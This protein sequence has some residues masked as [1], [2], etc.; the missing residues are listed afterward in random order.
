MENPDHEKETKE[1][2][3]GN[4][5]INDNSGDR[6]ENES[7]QKID[8]TVDNGSS[9]TDKRN[10]STEDPSTE[11][12]STDTSST[13][14]RTTENRTTINR[15][16]EPRI[17]E[18]LG[19]VIENYHVLSPTEHL[20]MRLEIF[21]TDNDRIR[22]LERMVRKHMTLCNHIRHEAMFSDAV[23]YPVTTAIE[24]NSFHVWLEWHSENQHQKYARIFLRLLYERDYLRDIF[25][26]IMRSDGRGHRTGIVLTDNFHNGLHYL[27]TTFKMEMIL[28]GVPLTAFP[29]FSCC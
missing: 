10:H 9:E 20:L 17:T 19:A 23:P 8:K 15:T 3:I 28:K 2:D 14:Y 16:T 12:R 21:F 26:R 5:G 11:N 7:G 27:A 25:K 18:N 24:R 13:E 4:K 29:D 6:I 22:T 1:R